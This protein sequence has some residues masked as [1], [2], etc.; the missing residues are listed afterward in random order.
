MNMSQ[1]AKWIYYRIC[2]NKTRNKIKEDTI[3]EAVKNLVSMGFK[4]L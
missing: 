4:L 2:N 1:T 3:L